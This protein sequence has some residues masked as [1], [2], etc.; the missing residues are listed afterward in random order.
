MR[1]FL[2]MVQETI[3]AIPAICLYQQEIV[4]RLH[5]V[6]DAPNRKAKNK[7]AYVFSAQN[8][9]ANNSSPLGRR[10]RQERDGERS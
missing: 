4:Y 6:M 10:H 7:C 8:V 9:S 1:L 3:F 5:V 2:G